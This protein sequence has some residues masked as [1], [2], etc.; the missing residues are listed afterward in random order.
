MISK[1]LVAYDGSSS[2]EKALDFAIDLAKSVNASVVILH[3]VNTC[4]ESWGV[5]SND[6]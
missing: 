6:T 1:I 5:V 2:A 4:I 3:V